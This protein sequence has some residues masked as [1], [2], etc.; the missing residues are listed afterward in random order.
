MGKF[1]IPAGSPTNDLGERLSPKEI[2]KKNQQKDEIIRAMNYA[3]STERKRI[4]QQENQEDLQQ[5]VIIKYIHKESLKKDHHVK[6]A[7]NRSKTVDMSKS[8]KKNS[9][10]TRE[11]YSHD[12]E[13]NQAVP[14]Q[15]ATQATKETELFEKEI[16]TERDQTTSRQQWE[17]SNTTG[18]GIG[19]GNP[20]VR[21]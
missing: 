21:K 9:K 17:R 1:L 2:D 12:Y 4:Q 7:F 14:D 16:L 15:K 5:E 3:T 10:G 8:S 20:V 18:D 19:W 13:F 11:E 6:A